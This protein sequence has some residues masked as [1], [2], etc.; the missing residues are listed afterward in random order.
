M[1]VLSSTMQSRSSMMQ[2]LMQSMAKNPMLSGLPADAYQF[3][4]DLSQIYE[5][6]AQEIIVSR[7]Q[8][9]DAFYL[10]IQ[11]TASV[12]VD[13]DKEVA[14]LRESDG[15]GEVGILLGDPRTAT[16]KAKETVVAMS[17]S[18]ENFKQC[19]QRFPKFGMV[20]STV[21]AKRLSQTLSLIPK[22][23]EQEELPSPEIVNLLPIPFIQRSRVLPLMVEDTKLTVGFVDEPQGNIIDRIRQFLPSMEIDSVSI[24]LDFFNKALDQISGLG[25]NPDAVVVEEAKKDPMPSKLRMLLERM[26][27][28]GAS[29]VHLSAKRKPHWR[30]DGSMKPIKDAAILQPEEAFLLL[31]PLMRSDRVEEFTTKND[32]DFA[33]SL[34]EYAR[35]RVNL[36]RD[37]N[38]T[39]AVLRLIPSKILSVGQL[40]LPP[41]LL[42]LSKQPKGLVL[43]TGATGSGKSTT[44]AAMIDYLNRTSPSH[45]ITLED[46]IE[47]VHNSH[48][49]LINQRE[50]G[51]HT[52]GFKQA[53]RAALRQDPDIVLVGELRD[54]ETVQLALEVANTGHLVFGTLH[55]MNAISSV[56]RI[57]DIFP[58]DQQNQIRSTLAE[59]LLGVVSQTLCK[60]KDG[61]RVA[62]IEVMVVNQAVSGQIRR[63]QTNQI[64]TSMQ[65]GKN[66][67][68][69]LLRDSLADLVRRNVVTY[70]EAFEKAV[71]KEQFA[72]I[73]G[74]VHRG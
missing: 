74:R 73:F 14:V 22:Y 44:L 28:E 37:N 60:R 39:S 19:L 38:G 17:L 70:E 5:Y 8:P 66:L 23:E 46:P 9:S 13:G 31:Q 45:I 68:N 48:E 41:I 15:F 43:V 58:A 47:F 35:F 63:G 26:V 55:T 57:I 7:N 25:E 2:L 42:E 71:D 6:D 27:A 29:D 62:A 67:G 40:G 32:C 59:V 72:K 61:G 10:L 65:T 52:N 50:I 30:V 34:E 18:Q 64:E 3:I 12:L 11:G 36:F 16:V 51:S 56:D 49:C 54:Q 69:Q 21:L 24:T 20:L 33:I 4:A 53:L 1:K